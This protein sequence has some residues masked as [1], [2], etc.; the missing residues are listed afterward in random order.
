MSGS[1]RRMAATVI[2][3]HPETGQRVVLE[4]GT[5]CPR[6]AVPLITNEEVFVGG[7]EAKADEEPGGG[8]GE[9][10]G[11][12]GDAAGTPPV[13]PVALVGEM[14]PRSGKG[15]SKAA[16]HAFA[17]ANGIEVDPADTAKA[18]QAKIDALLGN[19]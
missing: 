18:V 6:W 2:L 4:E 17:E 5:E 11:A 15:G 16:W 14:P 9:A 12:G 7:A 19:G 3:H 1:P 10:G 8:P 13:V